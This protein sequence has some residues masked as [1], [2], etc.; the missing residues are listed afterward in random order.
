MAKTI[1]KRQLDKILKTEREE[2]IELFTHEFKRHMDALEQKH[3]REK[4]RR[5]G[6]YLR[7]AGTFTDEIATRS[8]W[9]LMDE[10]SEKEVQDFLFKA[11]EFEQSKRFLSIKSLGI[12]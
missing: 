8:L 2:M 6:F 12:L 4:N 3:S 9:S 7:L 11:L 10:A 5:Y 1:T